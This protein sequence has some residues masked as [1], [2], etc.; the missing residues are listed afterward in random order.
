MPGAYFVAGS[1]W[2]PAPPWNQTE[3]PWFIEGVK[4]K[5]KTSITDPYEDAQTG[6]MCITIVRS[7]D[8]K[9]GEVLGVAGVDMFIDKI[10]EITESAGKSIQTVEK[11]DGSISNVEKNISETMNTTVE[12]VG[13]IAQSVDDLNGKI[14]EQVLHLAE[15]SSAIK[16]MTENITSIDKNTGAMIEFVNQLVK[17]AEDEHTN[18]EKATAEYQQVSGDSGALVEINGLIAGVA[19]QTNLLAMN[20]AIEAAHAGDAGKGFAVVADEIRK[21]SEQTSVQ[22]KKAN[23]VIV[24]IKKHIEQ[25][26]ISS[27][28]LSVAADLTADV[29]QKVEQISL[30]VRNSMKEQAIRS[31]QVLDSMIHIDGITNSIKTGMESIL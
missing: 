31:Q 4:N 8:G 27:K 26:L 16:E 30:E 23:A 6:K 5:G 11:V 21:L 2:D 20:A 17:N 13:N 24:S 9:N 22:S 15:S 1:G 7:A 28:S 12:T 10:S 19:S 29:I 18:L 3:R 25:L 14:Q